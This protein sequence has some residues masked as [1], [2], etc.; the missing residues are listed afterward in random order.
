MKKTS[1]RSKTENNKPIFVTA[2]GPKQKPTLSFE[3][4]PSRTKQSFAEETNI[5]KIIAKF[6]KTG[7][8]DHVSKHQAHYGDV[9]PM[10]L[11]EALHKVMHAQE[12]FDDLPSNLRNKF[13]NQ[14]AEFLEFVQ[15]EDNKEE[16]RQLGLLAE[17][18]PD[19]SIP[20]AAA[21]R[22]LD[23]VDERLAQSGA[24]APPRQETPDG[25]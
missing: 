25:G 13:N 19:P 17:P 12:M 24:A 3:D 18:E 11:Q 9:E 21:S 22:I 8:M 2:Y 10:E 23:A 4:A 1:T 16:M 20:M 14:P 15:N 5:N 6:H 7:V